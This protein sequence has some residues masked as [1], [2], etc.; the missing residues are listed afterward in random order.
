MGSE[1]LG[2]AIREV[3]TSDE[4]RKEAVRVM[5]EFLK[6]LYGEGYKG[7]LSIKWEGEEIFRIS[8]RL[9]SFAHYDLT[10]PTSLLEFYRDLRDGKRRIETSLAFLEWTRNVLDRFIKCIKELMVVS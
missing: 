1:K 10:S 3:I 4:H 5:G 8:D 2:R 6:E 9:L 7:S